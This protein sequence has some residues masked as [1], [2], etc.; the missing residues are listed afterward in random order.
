MDSAKKVILL[1]VFSE[2]APLNAV[3]DEK[4]EKK[5]RN[6]DCWEDTKARSEFMSPP[7]PSIKYEYDSE[8]VPVAPETVSVIQVYDMDTIDCA[9]M[10]DRPLV[11]N[12]ADDIYPGG[13]VNM[14]SF[15]QEESLFRRTNLHLTLTKDLYPLYYD[16]ALYSPDIRVLK[17]SELVL[18]PDPV[19]TLD[20]IACPAVKYPLLTEEDELSEYD[21]LQLARK[22]KT[23]LQVAKIHGHDTVIFGAMGCGAWQNPAKCVARVFK[24]VLQEYNGWLSNYVFAILKDVDYDSESEEGD[25]NYDVFKTVLMA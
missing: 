10:F 18:Y 25:S 2:A 5:L 11:L 9:L 20:F 17:S 22:I 6:I 12:M 8:F 24:E 13:W 7:P 4:T 16:E 21:C 19:P 1:D 14:G 15:A 3:V 23:I